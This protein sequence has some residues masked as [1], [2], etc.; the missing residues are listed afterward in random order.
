[1]RPALIR[2]CVVVT[3]E[4]RGGTQIVETEHSFSYVEEL[5]AFCVGLRNPNIVDR[6]SISGEDGE[7]RTRVVTFTLE[8]ISVLP[9]A[10][11]PEGG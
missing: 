4:L 7:G 2:R 1:M 9:P 11:P 3:R 6:L 10:R 8:S 5:I